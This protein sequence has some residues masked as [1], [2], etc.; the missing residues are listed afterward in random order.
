MH[1]VYGMLLGQLLKV[2]N[3]FIRLPF[4]CQVE[5]PHLRF[6]DGKK[7]YADARVLKIIATLAQYPSIAS[8]SQL[9]T[10]AKV[11]EASIH[12]YIVKAR[13]LVAPFRV[14]IMR[15]AKTGYVIRR[16][17]PAKIKE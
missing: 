6:P 7:V 11:S 8:D 14:E 17:P 10:A 16:S 4:E 5:Y 2:S 3:K 1:V 12:V 9:A 13:K 15:V